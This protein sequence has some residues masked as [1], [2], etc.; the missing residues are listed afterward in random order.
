MSGGKTTIRGQISGRANELEVAT[1]GIASSGDRIRSSEHQAAL[2][3]SQEPERV[4]RETSYRLQD[5]ICIP[6]SRS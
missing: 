3:R 6:L 1:R 5:G 4:E 2:E